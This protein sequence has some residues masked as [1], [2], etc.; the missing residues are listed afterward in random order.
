MLITEKKR[1]KKRQEQ[2]EN[3]NDFIQKIFSLFEKQLVIF[4]L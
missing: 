2:N 1:N 3:F 4:P